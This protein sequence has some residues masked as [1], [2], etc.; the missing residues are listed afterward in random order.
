MDIGERLEALR[1]AQE[2]DVNNLQLL[3]QRITAR[4]GAIMELE[5]ILKDAEKEE[6]P[7]EKP[8]EEKK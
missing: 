8:T 2:R 3:N 1:K 7:D 5:A 6:K 4:T